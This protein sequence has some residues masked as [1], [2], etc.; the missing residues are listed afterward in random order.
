MAL[1]TRIFR[2]AGRFRR[3]E[4]EWGRLLTQH[5]TFYDVLDSCHFISFVHSSI[6]VI[7]TDRPTMS[8]ALRSNAAL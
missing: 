6:F 8:A 3:T 7:R 5:E 2:K 1:V 4:S